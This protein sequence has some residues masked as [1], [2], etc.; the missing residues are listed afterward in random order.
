[1]KP[2]AKNRKHIAWLTLDCLDDRTAQG[3]RVHIETCEGCRSYWKEMAQTAAALRTENAQAGIETSPAFHR[4]VTARIE[5]AAAKPQWLSILMLGR[6]SPLDWR[7]GLP[8]CGGIAAVILALAFLPSRPSAPVSA[9]RL[10]PDVTS[11]QLDADAA[12]TIGNYQAVARQSLENLDELINQQGRKRTPT[13]QT[14]TAV[15]G[16][17]PFQD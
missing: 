10:A 7:W 1:M 9:P 16:V 14:Y 11:A 2:C 6:R 3:L 12:P 8:V 13:I 5:A 15:F 17:A 4:R